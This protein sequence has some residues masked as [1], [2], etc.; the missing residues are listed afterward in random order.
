[1]AKSG[2]SSGA[3]GP[4][5]RSIWSVPRPLLW[6]VRV[7]ATGSAAPNMERAEERVAELPAVSGRSSP[8]SWAVASGK[9]VSS[10]GETHERRAANRSAETARATRDMG[11]D[12]RGPALKRKILFALYRWSSGG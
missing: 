4:C 5:Q 1:M 6:M 11:G 10:G 12:L 3:E 7:T 9:V 2:S 8:T